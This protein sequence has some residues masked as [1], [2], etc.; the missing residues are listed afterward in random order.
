M[1]AMNKTNEDEHSKDRKN[2]MSSN[3]ARTEQLPKISTSTATV[4]RFGDLVPGDVLIGP[5]GNEVTVT[6][7]YDAHTP[8]SMYEVESEDG[9]TVVVSGNH[10]W[11]V[12]TA[13]DRALHNLRIRDGRRYFGQLD[14]QVIEDMEEV[15]SSDNPTETT[16]IDMISLCRMEGNEKGIN[17]LVRVA[18][19]LGPVSE[20]QTGYVD[21]Y[22]G[23]EVTKMTVRG[24]DARLFC[25]QVLC[26]TGKRKYKKRYPLIA[27]RV[28][29]TEAMLLLG[30]DITVPSS[31]PRNAA[32]VAE[33]AAQRH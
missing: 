7:V 2:E 10:L 31:S 30:D 33:K 17:A 13:L 21:Y 27:G 8:E 25:Q 12:V 3:D 22:T 28:V 29:T 32:T 26:L 5:G 11:Y 4:K 14:A 23:E 19:S 24:Y 18:E 6:T 15:S 16:L 9:K 1:K 20:N